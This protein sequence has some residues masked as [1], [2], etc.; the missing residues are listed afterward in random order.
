MKKKYILSFFVFSIL[1]SVAHSADDK[2]DKLMGVVDTIA[3][4]LGCYI[5][6][7][8]PFA[9]RVLHVLGRKELSSSNKVNLLSKALLC[10][11]FYGHEKEAMIDCVGAEFPK[12]E[13]E[14][15]L[16]I[17][18]LAANSNICPESKT[19]LLDYGFGLLGGI[20]GEVNLKACFAKCLLM[21][22]DFSTQRTEKI[23][24]ILSVIAYEGLAPERKEALEVLFY[25]KFLNLL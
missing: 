3:A 18:V 8:N 1:T 4:N 9:E 20:T 13:A 19:K 17:V 25:N 24:F 12:V 15:V 22:D 21:V 16:N 11:E 7:E 14:R 23:D 10:K 2:L 6:P 5:P